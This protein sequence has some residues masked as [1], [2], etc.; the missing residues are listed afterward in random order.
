MGRANS[1]HALAL[2]S[3]YN[4]RLIQKNTQQKANRL[5]VFTINTVLFIGREVRKNKKN[6]SVKVNRKLKLI[7]PKCATKNKLIVCFNN[8]CCSIFCAVYEKCQRLI[9]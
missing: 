3:E 2:Y 4:K 7:T 8:P 6:V 5:F 1:L 9:N